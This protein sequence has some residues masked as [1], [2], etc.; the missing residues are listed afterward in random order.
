MVVGKSFNCKFTVEIDFQSGIL[1]LHMLAKFEQNQMVQ[2][3]QKV[4]KWFI[5]FD[6]H[7]R[8]NWKMFLWLKELFDNQWCVLNM[9]LNYSVFKINHIL[10][11][12]S[13]PID[14]VLIITDRNILVPLRNLVYAICRCAR[15]TTIPFACCWSDGITPGLLLSQNELIVDVILCVI[16]VFQRRS[17]RNA[18][19]QCIIRTYRLGLCSLT[20][21][22][23]FLLTVGPRCCFF[24]IF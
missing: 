14:L 2:T 19:P 5:I 3:I 22:M 4:M 21:L 10:F 9:T 18:V 15:G 7:W 1:Y 12:T 8:H 23:I 6:K 11:L 24:V 16:V 13:D 17:N 20:F